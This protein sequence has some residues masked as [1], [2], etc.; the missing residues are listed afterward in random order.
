M[1]IKEALALAVKQL[2]PISGTPDLDAEILLAETLAARR[3]YLLAHADEVLSSTQESAFISFLEQRITGKP[4]AYI[5][6]MKEFYGR[7]FI[8]NEHVL[9]PR[10]ET[11]LLIDEVLHYCN[12]NGMST[13]S[14]L[15]IGTGSGCIACTLKM[16]LPDADVTA[17]DISGDALSVARLNADQLDVGISFYEGDLFA[18]LPDILNGTFDIVVSNPPYLPLSATVSQ[19]KDSR[20]LVYEPS[21]ALTP[22][23]EDFDIINRI[24]RDARDWLTN[25]GLLFVEIGD[26][27]GSV[28]LETAQHYFSNHTIEVKKDLAGLDRLLVIKPE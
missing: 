9:V 27:Q 15:D 12:E 28:A 21:A 2:A 13:P 25:E 4:I 17:T 11:E 7:T 20:A 1:T 23:E 6:G 26:T 14:I 24:V 19:E 8:V 10:P 22:G 3:E 5:L 18:A 16:E